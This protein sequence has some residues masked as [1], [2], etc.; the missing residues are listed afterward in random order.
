MFRRVITLLLLMVGVSIASALLVQRTHA[1]E[2][3]PPVLE[4]AQKLQIQNLAQKMQ[5]AQLQAQAA[6]RDFDASR[7]ELQS[8]LKSLEK[9]GYTLDL[10]SMAYVKKDA[11]KKK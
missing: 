4:Q 11:P 2:S 6:Q 9:D 8:L 5:I 3:Q 7:Q 1:S 10:Q